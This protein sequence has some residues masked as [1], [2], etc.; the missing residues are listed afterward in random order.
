MG[1]PVLSVKRAMVNVLAKTMLEDDNAMLVKMVSK[2]IQTAFVRQFRLTLMIASY[3][4][5]DIDSLR[6]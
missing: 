4:N 1:Q 2:N 6:L 3:V 5:Y